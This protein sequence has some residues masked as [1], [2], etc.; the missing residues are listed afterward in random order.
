[1]IAPGP[2]VVARPASPAATAPP[3]DPAEAFARHAAQLLDAQLV[4]CEERF[5][6]G[7]SNSVLVVVVERDAVTWR[8]RLKPVYEKLLGNKRPT[9]PE[10]VRLEIIDRSTEEAVRRLCNTG[11]LQM[12][13]RA[14]RHLHPKVEMSTAQLSNEER[15]RIDSHRARFKRKLKMGRILAAEEL[16]DEA[17]D[18]IGEAILYAAR[19]SAVQARL[20]EP[21]KLEETL[22]PPLAACWGESQPLI[23][24]FLA[25]SNHEYGPI[26][27]ALQSSLAGDP[28]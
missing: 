23:Q 1:M 2:A 9:S 25:E 5:P 24:R 10:D 26:I 16:F 7:E 27:Q 19:A 18:A 17:R 14:T 8:E 6:D 15:V 13:I 12:R 28:V 11:L 4:A 20:S 21:E 22:L 3:A